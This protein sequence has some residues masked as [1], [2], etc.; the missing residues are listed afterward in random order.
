MNTA[1]HRQS[2]RLGTLIA[3]SLALVAIALP[4]R[5]VALLGGSPAG[6]AM[7]WVPI[8]LWGVDSAIRQN[9]IFGGS[10]AAVAVLCSYWNDTH[11][12]FFS[13]LMIPCWCIVVFIYHHGFRWNKLEHWR[14]MI[15]ALLPM[16][17]AVVVLVVIA[18][19][20]QEEKL[21]GTGIADGRSFREVAL[22]SPNPRGFF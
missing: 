3:I 20:N 1:M 14:G 8:L 22:Y 12:F 13:I 21:A 16:A 15:A 10:L 7:M 6:F 5:W 19:S 11:V 4:C 17:V 9:R 2:N 18:H